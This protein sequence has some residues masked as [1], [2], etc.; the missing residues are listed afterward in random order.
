V[1][2]FRDH[3]G[4]KKNHLRFSKSKWESKLYREMPNYVNRISTSTIIQIFEKIGFE[5]ISCEVTRFDTL[6]IKREYL[7]K[8]FTDIS[9]DDL[10]ISTAWIVAKKN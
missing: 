6:P 9:E 4:G 3:L 5:I 7:D 8:E 10:M 2:D 1:V